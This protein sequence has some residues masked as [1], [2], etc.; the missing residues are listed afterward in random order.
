[1]RHDTLA[2]GA[3]LD[4]AEPTDT[5]HLRSASL[6]D[7]LV[8]EEVQVSQ[9]QQALSRCQAPCR[10]TSRERRGLDPSARVAATPPPFGRNAR[11]CSCR[12]GTVVGHLGLLAV[13]ARQPPRGKSLIR[14]PGTRTAPLQTRPSPSLPFRADR[15]VSRAGGPGGAAPTPTGL[16]A[17]Q[18]HPWGE[19][20]TTRARSP[21]LRNPQPHSKAVLSKPHTTPP[22]LFSHWRVGGWVSS[23]PSDDLH[24]RLSPQVT[25]SGKIAVPTLGRGGQVAVTVHRGPYAGLAT[26]HRA[27][28]LDA[29]RRGPRPG[30]PAVGVYGAAPRRSRQAGDRGLLAAVVRGRDAA[31]STEALE[32]RPELPEP[33]L[34]FQPTFRT[35]VVDVLAR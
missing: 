14:G 20:C 12:A 33:D 34:A 11:A 29:P 1:M 22:P 27:C 8:P 19:T 32:R 4:P 3:D 2:I 28:S 13:G 18:S 31:L 10:L 16:T 15:P 23:P 7:D 17:R 5:L 26:A 24:F 25:A 21:Q 6:L 30:R 35:R 9:A